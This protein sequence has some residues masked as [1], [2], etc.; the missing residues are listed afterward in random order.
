[1]R[2]VAVTYGTRGDVQPIVA[3]SQALVRAGHEVLMIGPPEWSAWAQ[4]CGV[5]Y[6]GLGAN[7]EQTMGQMSDPH[8]PRAV[9]EF[10]TFML[11]QARGQ[12]E[13]VPELTKGADL[14]IGSSLAVAA[15]TAAE[16]HSIS[17]CYV[18]FC[19]VFFPSSVHPP[20][21]VAGQ[22]HSRLFNALAW[23]VMRLGDR[24]LGLR[25]LNKERKRL[26]LHEVGRM[27]EYMMAGNVMLACDA[28][29]AQ[30][31]PDTDQQVTQC[32]YF[33]LEQAEELSPVLLDFLDQKGPV[34]YAGFG[35]MHNH[36]PQALLNMALSA[37]RD[38]GARL[39][40]SY[41]W[42]WP[43]GYSPSPDC[44]VIK[45]ANH[46]KLF[47]KVNAVIHHGGAGT[48]ATAARAGAPQLIVPHVLDQNY[49][50]HRVFVSGLGP[51]SVRRSRLSDRRLAR[52]LGACLGQE[53]IIEKARQTGELIRAR[54]SLAEAVRF[55]ENMPRR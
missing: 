7:L 31:P 21:M 36:R 51:R 50:A 32:G 27:W 54:D 42:D 41:D 48:T 11:D 30:A 15:P 47:S 26:G 19:P 13:Q 4:A 6:A 53:A 55:I 9:Y 24:A 14:V 25:M 37:A 38:S 18:V 8:K 3:L 39:V 22:N 29:L 45:G 35:S 23:R 20:M 34:A 10:L 16:L 17:Y 44:L 5:D 33:H 49:W 46:Q 43:D 1:M 28:S 2:I 40:F 52:G 12:F